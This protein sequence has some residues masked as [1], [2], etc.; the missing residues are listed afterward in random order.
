MEE[1]CNDCCA[2]RQSVWQSSPK[3]F[4]IKHITNLHRILAVKVGN[5]SFQKRSGSAK[6]QYNSQRTPTALFPGPKLEATS[7]TSPGTLS[8]NGYLKLYASPIYLK[9]GRPQFHL[10]V[11]VIIVKQNLLQY[12]RAEIKIKTADERCFLKFWGRTEV[13]TSL[14]KSNTTNFGGPQTLD[15]CCSSTPLCW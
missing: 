5:G 7:K 8:S 6:N 1:C 4:P 12:L 11:S 10:H 13:S 14:T 15:Y 9:L 3:D 2:P